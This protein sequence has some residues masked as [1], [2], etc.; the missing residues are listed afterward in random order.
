MI[1]LLVSL[2]IL[3]ILYSTVRIY[4][5]ET[6]GLNISYMVK[7]NFI[8]LITSQ[9]YQCKQLSMHEETFTRA[10]EIR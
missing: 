3:L 9:K 8:A 6:E 7:L 5:R 10:R 1:S 4:R 2:L